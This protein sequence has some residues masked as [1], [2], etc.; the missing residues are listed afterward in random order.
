[1]LG[2]YAALY[3]AYCI[4]M[5]NVEMFLNGGLIQDKIRQDNVC[6]QST[7]ALSQVI[8]T[9]RCNRVK[10]LKRVKVPVRLHS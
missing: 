4:P 1:M 6:R 7:D 8:K 10:V 5:G 9:E 3:N 2:L